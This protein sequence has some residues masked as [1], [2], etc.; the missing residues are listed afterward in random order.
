MVNMT[1][2]DE[3]INIISTSKPIHSAS[4][5]SILSDGRAST[6]WLF[7][8]QAAK[9]DINACDEEIDIRER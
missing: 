9:C 5:E 3:L 6:G 8:R 7:W 1:D 2:F 4:D